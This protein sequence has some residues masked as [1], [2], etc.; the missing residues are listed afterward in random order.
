MTKPT[1]E[2]LERIL[3]SGA[4]ANIEILPNGEIRAVP[5]HLSFGTG[6]LYLM[7]GT[8]E[9]QHAVFIAKASKPGPIGTN[10]PEEDGD[11]HSL[12]PG[13]YVLTFPTAEQAKAVA[14]ALCPSPN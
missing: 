9:G 2:E 10:N 12:K 6:A 11:L 4:P 7:T 3:A 14:D 13:E 8:Y 5:C 1:I